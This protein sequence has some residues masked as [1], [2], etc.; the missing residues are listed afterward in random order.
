MSR[1]DRGGEAGQ[2]VAEERRQCLTETE[3]VRQ[4]RLQQR[5][6]GNVS[7]RQRRWSRPGCGR[8][9]GDPSIELQRQRR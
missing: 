7:Q 9:E 2:V 6:E 4:A 1:G 3:E 5:S 8:G